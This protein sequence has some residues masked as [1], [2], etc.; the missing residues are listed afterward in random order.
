MARNLA[1]WCGILAMVAIAWSIVR[2]G[3]PAWVQYGLAVP[4]ALAV[5]AMISVAV[6][7]RTRRE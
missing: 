4:C 5:L 6:C 7:S 1:P 2:D 3:I